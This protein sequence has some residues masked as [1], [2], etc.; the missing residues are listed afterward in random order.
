MTGYAADRAEIEDLTARYLFAMDYNDPRAYAD[1]FARDAV[2]DWAKGVIEGREAI[3]EEA[4]VIL[5]H[6]VG[7]F[8]DRH[9]NPAKLRH[10][11]CHTAMRVEGDRAWTTGFW[12]E[13]TN[14]GA[15]G[16]VATP[17]FGTFQDELVREDGRWK[18]MRRMIYNE[19]YPD[20]LS[21]PEN[22]MA[23]MDRAE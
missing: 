7:T 2:L 10:T 23:A 18:F 4:K 12:W 11:A 6:N 16:G 21:G 14:G 20:R 1:C 17:S 8:K 9:G 19:F 13:M 3:F 5:A 22:P 15:D